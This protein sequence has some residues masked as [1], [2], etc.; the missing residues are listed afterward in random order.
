MQTHSAAGRRKDTPAIFVAKEEHRHGVACTRDSDLPQWPVVAVRGLNMEVRR[1]YVTERFTSP[2][3]LTAAALTRADGPVIAR[4]LD[5]KIQKSPRLCRHVVPRRVVGVKGIPLVC[6]FGKQIDQ[7]TLGNQ[8]LGTKQQHLCNP[9]A[10][11]ACIQ[12]RAGI[13]DREAT[14]GVDQNAFALAM[15]FPAE[16]L[17]RLR[18]TKFKT[19]V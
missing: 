19:S 5:N 11:E 13:V 2:P 4:Q 17:A 8:M 15:E 12:E 10:G 1:R 18:V 7:P 14:S 16:R 9:R 3:Q 6:P